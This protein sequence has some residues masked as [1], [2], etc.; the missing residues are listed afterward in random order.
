MRNAG[1]RRS[2]GGRVL[3]VQK[4]R[5]PSSFAGFWRR[6]ATSNPI[7]TT[8]TPTSRAT[9]KPVSSGLK[10]SHLMSQYLHLFH[11]KSRLFYRLI[12][13]DFSYW[14][15]L[16]EMRTTAF[17]KTWVY[18]VETSPWTIVVVYRLKRITN[19]M[20]RS[21]K[22]Q[23]IYNNE[24]LSFLNSI[25]LL[26][27]LSLPEL[28]VVCNCY[29]IIFCLLECL[30]GATEEVLNLILGLK[31]VLTASAGVEHIERSSEPSG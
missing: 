25:C 29:K 19:R 3:I 12:I 23:A 31:V 17:L 15:T 26:P 8:R 6:A 13:G 24:K 9:K 28:A 4:I 20:N 7:P 16:L 5:R 14:S 22:Y 27:F 11:G 2:D 18:F 1:R 10:P 21:P 30:W